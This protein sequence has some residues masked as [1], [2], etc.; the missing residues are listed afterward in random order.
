MKA[1]PA[2][3]AR[4]IS[5][6][7]QVKEPRSILRPAVFGSTRI[8]QKNPNRN[9]LVQAK[10]LQPEPLFMAQAMQA[11]SAAR[12]V[13]AE[14]PERAQRILG[15]EAARETRVA[16]ALTCGKRLAQAARNPLNQA[17]GEMPPPKFAAAVPRE[18][19]ARAPWQWKPA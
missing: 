16:P 12:K 2:T 6:E 5:L 17:D 3:L 7:E 15:A 10:K 19:A 8:S 13:L 14:A 9:G 1:V 11:V 4:G 18:A